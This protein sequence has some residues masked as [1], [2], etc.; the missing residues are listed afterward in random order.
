MCWPERVNDQHC[1]EFAGIL[2]RG[3][4]SG[5]SIRAILDGAQ[6]SLSCHGELALLQLSGDA[7]AH[8]Q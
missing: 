5:R 1:R 8:L 7:S 2:Y 4:A 3:L 6:I